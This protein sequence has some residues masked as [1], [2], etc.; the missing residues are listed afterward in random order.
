MFKVSN[1]QIKLLDNVTANTWLALYKSLGVN[2]DF[3][4]DS[5]T[6]ASKAE[7]EFGDSIKKANEE[8]GFNWPLSPTTQDDLNLMHKEIETAPKDQADRLRIIHDQL[9]SREQQKG[10]SQI[11]I[12]WADSLGQF[13]KKKAVNKE[14]PPNAEPFQKNI[15]YG[16]VYLGYPH[17]GKSPELCMKQKDNDNL[18]QTCRLHDTI[19]CDFNIALCDGICDTDADL[20]DW[21]DQNKITM[22]TKEDMLKYNGWAKIG[23]VLNKDDIPAMDQKNLTT[24][25]YA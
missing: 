23:E 8:F 6:A 16:D 17:V 18:A 14:M 24:S 4:Q 11:Q 22:F 13:F 10:V 12:G 21:F 15:N 19:I 9:H 2:P 7:N 25:Y 1:L 3:I 5:A 20:S